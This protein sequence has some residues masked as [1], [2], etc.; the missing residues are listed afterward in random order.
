MMK[1]VELTV[2]FLNKFDMKMHKTIILLLIFFVL[3]H[4]YSQQ[5]DVKMPLTKYKVKNTFFKTNL[6][7]I[8]LLEEQKAEENQVMYHELHLIVIKKISDKIYDIQIFE[9][10][11]KD[12][13]NNSDTLEAIGYF[14]LNS[15]L[16]IVKG[17]YVPEIFK[18]TKCKK[19]FNINIEDSTEN[20]PIIFDPEIWNYKLYNG[21]L[22]LKSG[23]IVKD[24]R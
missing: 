15:Y 23:I 4:A 2:F 21:N 20:I 14:Y 5:D 18:K 8:L 13:L 1:M 22:F 6:K 9:G 11:L 12:I 7:S 16:F 10:D 24:G 19:V 3:T 17:Y